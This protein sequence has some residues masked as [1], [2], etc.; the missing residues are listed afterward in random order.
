MRSF[1][2]FFITD[3]DSHNLFG[4]PIL[5]DSA[6]DYMY[7]HNPVEIG[8]E[9]EAYLLESLYI[10]SQHIRVYFPIYLDALGAHK[11]A[12]YLRS[13]PDFIPEIARLGEMNRSRRGPLCFDV[14]F[15]EVPPSKFIEAY[16]FCKTLP[17]LQIL[18]ECAEKL[19][20]ISYSPLVMLKD[21][22]EYII[23]DSQNILPSTRNAGVPGRNF[24]LFSE[25]AK[26]TSNY[27]Y[28]AYC[29]A[30][31]LNSELLR[32]MENSF[33]ES[34]TYGENLRAAMGADIFYLCFLENAFSDQVY[35]E[36]YYDNISKVYLE[37]RGQGNIKEKL[38]AA[39]EA[40]LLKGA[41]QFLHTLTTE[42]LPGVDLHGS[43][44]TPRAIQNQVKIIIDAMRPIFEDAAKSLGYLDSDQAAE[45][46]SELDNLAARISAGVTESGVRSVAINAG[47]K[48]REAIMFLLSTEY[49][50]DT[51]YSALSD[52]VLD[53]SDM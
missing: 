32:M 39:E 25:K 20:K 28:T 47:N 13:M 18:R 17:S 11:T 35:P 15:T 24:H 50:V 45:F 52:A 49:P 27:H 43:G 19:P 37:A 21:I 14:S 38:R 8:W 31:N 7:T 3:L 48:I 22:M 4:R 53:A 51:I 5:P 2:K 46:L 12:K 44:N 26:Q 30:R 42:L 10:L 9:S 34:S 1:A 23:T 16:R 40:Y 36:E 33:G 29:H 6:L 41:S